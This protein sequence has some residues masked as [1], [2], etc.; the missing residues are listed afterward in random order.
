MRIT[1]GRDELH[2]AALRFIRDNDL[3]RP[4]SQLA[5]HVEVKV[6]VAMGN[7]SSGTKL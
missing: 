1:S 7:A 6:A 2:D 3:P 5:R 4:A